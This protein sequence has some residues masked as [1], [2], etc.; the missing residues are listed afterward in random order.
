MTSP[1]MVV[2]RPPFSGPTQVTEKV[3]QDDDVELGAKVVPKPIMASACWADATFE[4]RNK[5]N[6][7]ARLANFLKRYLL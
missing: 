6:R 3:G 7:N 1:L 2:Y 4:A 5:E